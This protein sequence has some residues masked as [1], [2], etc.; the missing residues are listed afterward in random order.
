MGALL[1][2]SAMYTI[3]DTLTAGEGWSNVFRRKSL[4]HVWAQRP[5]TVEVFMESIL[6]ELRGYPVG[7]LS[8]WYTLG[9]LVVVVTVSLIDRTI[10][11]MLIGSVKADLGL[12]DFQVSLLMGTAFGICYV[13][14]AV[15]FGWAS[16]RFPRPYVIAFGVVFWSIA[17]ASGGLAFSFAALFVSRMMVGVGE[18]SLSPSAY[19]L[20]GDLF[21]KRLVPTALAVY[22]Y[23]GSI[24]L[25]LA[26][27]IGGTLA[28]MAV[29][30]DLSFSLPLIG[31]LRPW[32]LVFLL[33]GSPG[34]LLG[35]LALTI[36]EPRSKISKK[37]VVSPPPLLPFLK[38]NRTLI[39]THFSGFS[40]GILVIY[41]QLFWFPE[42]LIRFYDLRPSDVGMI[43]GGASLGGAL[44]GQ[45]AAVK[46]IGSLTA[47]GRA[48][49]AIWSYL[50]ML[51]GGLIG[52]F[53]AF[54]THSIPI[55]I[56]G[57]TLCIA[58]MYPVQTCGIT[59]LQNFV[60][61]RLLGRMT[62]MFATSVNLIG[63]G[64][65]ASLVGFTSEYV[66]GGES[67]LGTAMMI[68]SVVG[69]V[70]SMGFLLLARGPMQRAMQ[71][72]SAAE[73]ATY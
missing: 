9:V 72:M 41:A 23:G 52:A 49:A 56:V 65:G 59:A 43:L 66:L 39:G 42:F 17:C 25:A 57:I 27:A 10:I 50:I 67:M 6:R 21:P 48:D 8:A 20:I 51:I 36:P 40:L 73:A 14:F 3:T 28:Q 58:C 69:I 2:K 55:T 22:H 68:V 16:D 12:D 33:V 54:G 46:L 63:L 60:P 44:I 15:P 38:E 62:G 34:L 31:E 11:T 4:A 64:A 29:E 70:L 71:Q 32:Q 5:Q 7:A 47:R 61:S 26:L 1:T 35:L 45:F 19:S 18:A 13:L 30:G 37:A 53:L 24:G